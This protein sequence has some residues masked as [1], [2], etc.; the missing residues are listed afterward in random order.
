MTLGT[1]IFGAP[2]AAPET[3][4]MRHLRFC[5]IGSSTSSA[6]SVAGV[7]VFASLCGRPAAGAIVL[8]MLGI[9]GAAAILFLVRKTRIDD[10]WLLDR[11]SGREGE[12]A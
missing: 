5:V 1:R 6:L 11:G 7:D 4:A 12:S 9:T 10:A 3:P 8:A 2:M